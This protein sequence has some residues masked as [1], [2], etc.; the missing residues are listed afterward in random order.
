MRE[1]KDRLRD[2]YG[3]N[4]EYFRLSREVNIDYFDRNHSHNLHIIEHVSDGSIVLDLACGTAELGRHIRRK[5]RY[6]GADISRIGLDMAQD[7]KNTTNQFHLVQCDAARLPFADESV[8]DVVST[9]SLEH[10][11]EVEDILLEAKRILKNRGSLILL[12]P[13]YDNFLRSYPPSLV[14]DRGAKGILRR[15]LYILSQGIRQFKLYLDKSYY[16]F[17]II[18]ESAVLDS[19]WDIDND[20]VH[21]VSIRAVLNFLMY[22]NFDIEYIYR[23]R[24]RKFPWLN[25]ISLFRYFST[26]VLFIIARKVDGGS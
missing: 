21:L 14:F 16:D 26:P 23:E 25:T 8:D 4:R 17:P 19:C 7:Y 1:L 18:Q 22:N 9:Y 5:A 12:S 3:D 6:I 13:A 10:F 15:V 2:F 24:S 11:V 20:A